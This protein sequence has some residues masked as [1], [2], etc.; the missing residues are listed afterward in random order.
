VVEV[1]PATA[2]VQAN[3]GTQQFTATVTG[4]VDTS[5]VWSITNDPGDGSLGAIDGNG[6]YEAPATVPPNPQIEVRATS[7]EDGTRYGTAAVMVTPPVKV[8]VSPKQASVNA[9]LTQQFVVS[10]DNSAD[11]TVTWEV[12][13]GAANG[14]IDSNGLYT[15]PKNIP[16]P[17]DVTVKV[18]SAVDPSKSD[19]A[20]V[21]VTLPVKVTVSP[22]KATVNIGFTRQFSA[23][24]DN[25]LDK[26]V[27]WSVS[28]G[29]QNGT[30]DA[31]GLYTAPAQVPNPN[32]FTVIATSKA[33]PSAAGVARVTVMPPIQVSVTPQGSDVAIEQTVQFTAAVGNNSDKT[34]TWS[35]VGGASNGTV[36]G[37]GLYTAPNRVPDPANVQVKATS[38]VDPTKSATADVAVWALVE[39]LAGSSFGDA[40]GT[41]PAAQFGAPAAVAI[42]PTSGELYVADTANNRIKKVTQAGVVSN[43]CGSGSYGYANGACGS[44]QFAAPAGIAIAQNGDIYVSDTANNRIR[45]ISGGSVSLI[46][47]SGTRGFADNNTGSSARF[48]GPMGI[49]VDSSGNIYVADTGNHRIRKVA[50]SGATSTLAGNGTAGFADGA[51]GSA[52]FNGPKA[53]AVGSGTDVFVADTDNNRIRRVNSGSG[54]TTTF[55]GTGTAGFQDGPGAQAMFNAPAGAAIDAVGAVYISDAQ[56]YVIR[57]INPGGTV[58]TLAGNRSYGYTEGPGFQAR[59]NM[60]AGLTVTSDGKLVFVADQQNSKI[61]RVVQGR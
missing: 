58:M 27:D 36:D 53:V 6:L 8:T 61:R 19:T 41:G 1:T 60:P 50:G 29:A 34:V 22:D 9:G 20:T 59:F 39:L 21:T 44:A 3:I 33:D 10:V 16:N 43:F 31:A 45:R 51:A 13:G 52:Q 23:T 57:K 38:A 15:A 2:S 28:G 4:A 25:T 18:T 55:A 17:P 48:A 30:I 7:V 32:V 35:V 49:A 47:G 11:Q 37:N 46:A 5:V 40:Q 12:V 24:V 56:S 26:S 54:Q 14:T 42:H